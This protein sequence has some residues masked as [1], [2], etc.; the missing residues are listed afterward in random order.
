ML[1]NRFAK[2]ASMVN[3]IASFKGEHI[4]CSKQ[5]ACRSVAAYQDKK[6]KLWRI[7]GD[8]YGMDQNPANARVLPSRTLIQY[9][10]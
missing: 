4:L 5:S 2:H 3:Q 9:E 1:G 8:K 6:L 7:S 10:E